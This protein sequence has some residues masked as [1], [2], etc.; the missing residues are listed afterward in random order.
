M[1]IFIT[2]GPSLE[3]LL[4]EEL[5][6]LGYLPSHRGFR[7]VYLDVT[8]LR[9]IYRINYCSRIASR[10]LLPLFTFKCENKEDLYREVAN[11]N[12]LPFFSQAKTFAI[13]ANVDHPEIRNSL[14]AA[15]V[16]KDAVCDQMTQKKGY[17]PS[18]DTKEPD[19][20]LNLFLRSRKGVLSLDTSGA[21]LHKRGYRQEGGEA[22]LRETLAAALLRLADYDPKDVMIDPCA[23][24][25]TLLIEAGLIANS[26]PPGIF[27]KKWGFM[28]LPDFSEKEWLQTKIIED[29]KR[30]TLK[31]DHFFGVEI[32]R[33]TSRIALSN[34]KAAGLHPFINIAQ[35]DFRDYEPPIA[36]NLMVTNPPYGKRLDEESMLVPLYRNLGDFMK[37]KLNKPARGFILTGSLPLSK[38][39]GLA[40]K[41]RTVLD[42]GG[43]ESRFLEFDIY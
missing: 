4:E 6:E 17:R 22:P 28:L 31:K 34:I 42:N 33:N 27:R 35:G 39:I 38:E 8:S 23:G 19:L 40:A 10:V 21:P 30:H 7:G 32:N 41:K 16:V 13:D 26:T 11:W 12:W 29:E 36:P 25:G 43:V 5:K 3:P 9:D 37:R 1:E 2:C 14:F 20:Q 18:V 15:Q 24:S